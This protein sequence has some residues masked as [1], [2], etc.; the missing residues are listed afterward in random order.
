MVSLSLD[1]GCFS[2]L[3][4]WLGGFGGLLWPWEMLRIVRPLVAGFLFPFLF[5]LFPSS[6]SPL[7]PLIPMGPLFFSCIDSNGLFSVE[8]LVYLDWAKECL[9]WPTLPTTPASSI[10]STLEQVKPAKDARA[11]FNLPYV[12]LFFFSRSRDCCMHNATLAIAGQTA[13]RPFCCCETT[14][15]P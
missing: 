14:C 9:T 5:F 11:A 7:P 10:L 13:T 2:L 15:T 4:W 8:S 1:R 3:A 12:V 6:L